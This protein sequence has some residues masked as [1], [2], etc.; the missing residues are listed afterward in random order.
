MLLIVTLVGGFLEL[1]VFVIFSFA[2]LLC[3]LVVI[4]LKG[5]VDKVTNGTLPL[6]RAISSYYR[7]KKTI[8]SANYNMQ[9]Y[10]VPLLLLHSSLA[11]LALKL[12]LTQFPSFIVDFVLKCLTVF[13]AILPCAVVNYY[14]M[15]IKSVV[16]NKRGV[17]NDTEEQEM[18]DS[19]L[20]Y[21][22]I[23]RCNWKLA[24]V[25]VKPEFLSK[26]LYLFFSVILVLIK[27]YGPHTG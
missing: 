22:T 23:G 14:C 7:I 24:G 8:V 10:L 3:H 12:Y 4:I 15:K 13:L 1:G 18:L 25:E 17:S 16:H 21:I 11:L 20:N 2:A 6:N 9:L 26:M 19:L 27:V 5:Y